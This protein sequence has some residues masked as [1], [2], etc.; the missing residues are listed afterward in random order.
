MKK[1]EPSEGTLRRMDEVLHRMLNTPP[2]PRKSAKNKTKKD[3]PDNKRKGLST[4]PD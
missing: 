2:D 4:P 3:K 1:E